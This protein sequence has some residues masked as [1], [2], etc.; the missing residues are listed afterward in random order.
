MALES[1]VFKDKIEF[2]CL[3]YFFD[4]DRYELFFFFDLFIMFLLFTFF[5]VLNNRKSCDFTKDFFFEDFLKLF[6]FFSFFL[7]LLFLL[8]VFMFILF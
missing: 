6:L 5:K 2:K 4:L 8:N 1:L 3:A 7:A